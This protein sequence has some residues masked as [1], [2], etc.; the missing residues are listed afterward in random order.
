MSQAGRGDLRKPTE[1][2]LSRGFSANL[3]QVRLLACR[4]MFMVCPAGFPAGETGGK[5]KN[6]KKK[7]KISPKISE[8]SI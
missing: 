2:E 6:K 4:L 8:G 5:N 1:V 7:K 3:I